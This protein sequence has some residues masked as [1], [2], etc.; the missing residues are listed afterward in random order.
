[1]ISDKGQDS[2]IPHPAQFCGHGA[3]V[4]GEKV[5]K[6][7]PVKGDIKDRTSGPLGLLRQIGEKLFP[8]RPSGHMLQLLGEHFI[9]LC[10]HGEQIADQTPVELTGRR[11]HSKDPLHIQEEHFARLYGNRI[12]Q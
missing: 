8:C 6:L 9:L 1:M 12:I 3:P 10:E 7:L 4:H 5:R 11:T 2:L